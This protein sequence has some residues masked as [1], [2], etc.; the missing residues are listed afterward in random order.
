MRG[1]VMFLTIFVALVASLNSAAADRRVA[2]IIGNGAYE[3]ADKL[4]NPVTDARNLRDTLKK[5]GFDEPNIVYGENLS[6]R[7]LERAIGRFAGLAR[8]A[9]VAL[10]YYAG[11]GATFG[12]TP[13]LVPV[14]ARFESL[15][16][17]PYELEPLENMI[18]ELRKAKGVRIAIIDACRDN[19]AEHD[20][21]RLS[22]R[23]GEIS[24]GLAPPR[25]PDGLILA[26]ATQY[27]ATAADGPPGGDSPFTAAL[28][29]YLPVPG[30]DVKEL[31]FAVG[32]DVL[33][34]TQDRQRPEVKVSF[35]G[36][37]ALVKADAGVPPVVAV[38]PVAPPVATDTELAEYY[39]AMRADTPA[40][41]DGFLGRYKATPL[42]D[43]ARRERDR[44][45]T[46][47]AVPPPLST[48]APPPPVIDMEQ[49][50]FAAAT[51]TGTLAGWDEFL[52]GHGSG[53][54]ANFARGQREKLLVPPPKVAIVVTP[55]PVVTGPCGGV[56]LAGLSSRPAGA[57][58]RN[59]ECALKRGDEFRECK[60][61]P[62]ML[63][64]PPGSFTM[65]SPA[66][67]PGR[68]AD[69]GPQ[70]VVRFARGFA[71]G[72]FAVTFAEWDACVAGGGC[73]GYRPADAGWGR[74]SRPVINVSWNDAQ[75]Y[76]AWLSK[77]T[78]GTYR[79]LSEAEREYVARAGTST[80]FWWGK[81]ITPK[82]ANYDG[83]TV[84]E[85]GGTEGEHRAQTVPVDSFAAN[86]WGLFNVHGNV[87]EWT[88]DCWNDTYASAPSDGSALTTGDCSRRVLR[89]GSWGFNPG[90]LRAATRYR[91]FP[92]FRNS[93]GGL[94]V[95]RTL[96]P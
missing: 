92:A 89:G 75:A 83:N 71:V 16:E 43:I 47:A 2:L 7:E 93:G 36:K 27:L 95:A 49:A 86:P 51:L 15:D 26:Y 53:A 79:L 91:N 9:D 56:V 24:R 60:D 44:L 59:E 58:S 46:I 8:D 90:N 63:V 42:A 61:C 52:R 1:L 31:F 68:F 5:I 65:G 17:M 76:V 41:L 14:D 35:F 54:F 82:Q 66:G 50:D 85:G 21:K 73:D 37:Y 84:Y 18:G 67:E 13:Y 4:A 72:K 45:A 29:K 22:A 6:K 32:Q 78:G 19:G 55:P 10:A 20:L 33:T 12:D 94:R 3:H 11:H 62:P 80:P 40:A 39:A 57:L 69:E 74:A 34:A 88:Q 96:L 23:G 48:T 25:N 28:L 64:V 77:R 81:S 30:L 87:W 70:H 38:A